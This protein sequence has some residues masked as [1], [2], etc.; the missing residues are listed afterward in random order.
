MQP[1]QKL[2]SQVSDISKEKRDIRSVVVA[3]SG[4][5]V[6]EPSDMPWRRVDPEK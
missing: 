4:C 6:S 5:A 2:Q 1:R 3:V